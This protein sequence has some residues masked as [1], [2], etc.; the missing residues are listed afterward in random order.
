V[1][2]RGGPADGDW[3]AWRALFGGRF[4]RHS[5]IA[6]PRFVDPARRD[7]RLRPDSP[8][9]RLGIKP[10]ETRRIGLKAD[11]PARFPRQ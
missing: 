7:Y 5:V 8:A 1:S 2:V 3:D 9:L 6:D 4:D 10:I 11:F